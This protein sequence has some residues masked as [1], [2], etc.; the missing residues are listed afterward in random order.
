MTGLKKKKMDKK[1]KAVTFQYVKNDQSSIG[2][3]TNCL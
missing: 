2:N 1:V 3:F